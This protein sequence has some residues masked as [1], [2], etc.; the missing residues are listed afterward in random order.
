LINVVAAGI[1]NPDTRDDGE[2]ID[3]DIE[4]VLKTGA[5]EEIEEVLQGF[6]AK[7]T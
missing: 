1:A 2:D 7:G 3:G 4:K 5:K 6:F